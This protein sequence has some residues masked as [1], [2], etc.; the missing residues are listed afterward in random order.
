MRR[1]GLPNAS[2]VD[3]ILESSSALFICGAIFAVISLFLEGIKSP[4][5]LVV[6]TSLP[7]AASL[8]LLV[9]ALLVP[10]VYAVGRLAFP[11]NLTLPV[12]HGS[13][14]YMLAQLTRGSFGLE[15]PPA[16]LEPALAWGNPAFLG[17]C[18][19]FQILLLSVLTAFRSG[20]PTPDSATDVQR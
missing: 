9:V 18:L 3:L 17:L 12:I 6:A 8:L 14:V 7:A 11:L 10:G 1:R 13:I 19:V 4:I 5:A 15:R 2:T 16:P 20:T